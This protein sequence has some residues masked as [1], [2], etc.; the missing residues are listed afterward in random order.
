M[1]SPGVLK[2]EGLHPWWLD[3]ICTIWEFLNGIGVDGVGGIFPPFFVFFFA[4]LCFSLLFSVF[5]VFFFSRFSLLFSYSLRGGPVCTNT[6]QN[7]PK[8]WGA[9]FWLGTELGEGGATKQKLNEARGSVNEGFGKEF[10]RKGNSV[11]RF[12]PFSEPLGSENYIFLSSSP[13]QILALALGPNPEV[14]TLV[15]GWRK[16]GVEFK[17]GSLHDGF[18][19]FGG[20][21]DPDNPYPLN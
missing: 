3:W 5:F 4:F 13:S 19:G 12:R 17:G 2:W 14:K 21:G 15:S 8:N 20:S 6:V 11:K 10:H 16:R 7:F 9:P 1:R 18:D